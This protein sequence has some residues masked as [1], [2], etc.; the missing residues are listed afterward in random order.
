MSGLRGRALRRFGRLHAFL[1][2]FLF[3]LMT[4]ILIREMFQHG[5]LDLV[6]ILDVMPMLNLGS[7]F[8]GFLRFSLLRLI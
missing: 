5:R 1:L 8:S 3:A 2:A 6:V 7:T 4:K